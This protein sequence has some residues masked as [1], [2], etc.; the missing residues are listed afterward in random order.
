MSRG[1]SDLALYE[2]GTIFRGP[3]GVAPMLSVAKRPSDEELA[4]IYAALPEQLTAVACVVTGE[5]LPVSG[6]TRA[7]AGGWQQAI[8][9]AETVARALGVRLERT[10]DSY[11]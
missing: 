11:A 9:F 3:L 2:V 8:A 4:A 10:A 1:L 6:G 7:V 5:W